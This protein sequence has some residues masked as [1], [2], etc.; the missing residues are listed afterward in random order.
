MLQYLINISIIW[1]A[2]LFVFELLFRKESFHQYNRFFLV[3]SLLLG[4]L[5][6]LANFNTLVAANTLALP[7]PT[8]QLVEIKNAIQVSE[9]STPALS[10]NYSIE[11]ILWVIYLAGVFIGI[12]FIALEIIKLIGL[13]KSGIKS[14]ESQCTIIETGQNHA[15]FSFFHLVFIRSRQDY[16]NAQWLLLIT[17]E[18]EHS[19]QLHCLDNLFLILLR[20]IFWFHP[21]PHIYFNRLRMVHEFQADQINANDNL[22][23][24]IFLIEQN[25]LQG[26]PI[27]AHSI[28][29]SPL[30][31][32]ITMLTKKR[33]TSVKLIK[34]LSIIPLAIMLVVCCTKSAHSIQDVTSSSSDPS[35]KKVIF[36]GNEITF[37]EIKVIPFQYQ[38]VI[39]EQKKA[40]MNTSLPDS[41]LL[42]DWATKKLIMTAVEK[43]IMPIAI[44]GQPIIGNE[45]QYFMPHVD[46]KYSMPIVLGPEIDPEAY[47]FTKLNDQLNKLEDGTYVLHVDRLVI[48]TKGM[49]AYYENPGFDLFMGSSEKLPVIKDEIKQGVEQKMIEL[50][51]GSLQCKPAHKNG[52][53][54]NVRLPL[55]KYQINVKGHMA[56]LVERAGC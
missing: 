22:A 28:N 40:F 17:H 9:I 44:N 10:S 33:S 19:K 55:N 6:P 38:K 42:E 35:N 30:K 32:R 43:D 18:K 47:L 26:A 25:L 51:N 31:T 5:L 16:N 48:D 29:Y 1:I 52:K 14:T 20:I 12:L 11:T 49:V 24:G 36:K 45:S 23:Y 54:L 8:R 7:Q 3:S 50:L 27:L 2:C 41:V 21:L 15:P 39:S 13:Y 56:K 4:L 37:G 34:Y 46:T 53:P